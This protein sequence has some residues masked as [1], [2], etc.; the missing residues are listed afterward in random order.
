MRQPIT[1]EYSLPNYEGPSFHNVRH[2]RL[3]HARKLVVRWGERTL[4]LVAALLAFAGWVKSNR[5]AH[6]AHPGN[7][8][9]CE[10]AR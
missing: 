2:Y 8:A 7:H 5:L 10:K 6:R 9:A 4:F 3:R 1:G